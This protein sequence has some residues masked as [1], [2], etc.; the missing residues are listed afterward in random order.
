MQQ[1]VFNKAKI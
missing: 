1:G